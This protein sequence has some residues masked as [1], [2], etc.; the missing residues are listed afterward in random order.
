MP[1]SWQKQFIWNQ[2]TLISNLTLNQSLKLSGS[3]YSYL[4]NFIYLICLD[5]HQGPVISWLISN[6]ISLF[7]C[8]TLKSQTM[9]SALLHTGFLY[10]IFSQLG[11]FPLKSLHSFLSNVW[12]LE[13]NRLQRSRRQ[14]RNLRREDRWAKAM[15]ISSF[16]LVSWWVC[17]VKELWPLER[18]FKLTTGNFFLEA[19]L[20]REIHN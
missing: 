4:Y 5:I 12:T 20:V 16:Y 8:C 11:H 19:P 3:Q 1:N 18:S 9:L 6:H 10:L 7:S 2:N 17:L 14:K 13:S 15:H